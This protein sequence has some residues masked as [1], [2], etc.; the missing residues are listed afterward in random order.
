[1][2][3]ELFSGDRE[4]KRGAGFENKGEREGVWGGIGAEH[5]AVKRERFAEKALFC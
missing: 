2:A 1:M 4:R 5:L 3:V